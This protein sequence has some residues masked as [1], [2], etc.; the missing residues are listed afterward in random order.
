MKQT[1]E[2]REALEILRQRLDKLKRMPWAEVDAY[3]KR[4]E[5]VES[6]GGR[7]FRVVTMAFWDMDAWASDLL[8]SA[9]ATRG[10]IYWRRRYRL[11]DSRGGPDDPT[12]EPPS[13]AANDAYGADRS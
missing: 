13:N 7:R 8:L 4:V 11:F 1:E 6:P 10:P 9:K 5:F 2:E 3:G 12:F